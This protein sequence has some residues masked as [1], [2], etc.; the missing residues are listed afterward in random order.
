MEEDAN[1]QLECAKVT[2]ALEVQKLDSNLFSSLAKQLW[3][4]M[5]SRGV[6][7]GQVISQALVSA[8]STVDSAFALH[9]CYLP[10][11]TWFKLADEI[12]HDGIVYARM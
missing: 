12:G 6:F 4:P 1:S 8:T 7:G 11:T 10:S 2:D 9:V 5:R 3:I